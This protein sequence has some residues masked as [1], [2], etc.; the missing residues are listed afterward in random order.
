MAWLL[1]NFV[2]SVVSIHATWN[3]LICCKTGLIV[4]VKT[5]HIAFNP[6]CSNVPKQVAHLCCP[7][8]PLKHTAVSDTEYSGLFSQQADA[9]SWSKSKKTLYKR[10]TAQQQAFLPGQNFQVSI[11]QLGHLNPFISVRFLL[12]HPFFPS[13]GQEKLSWCKSED[14]LRCLLMVFCI[15]ESFTYKSVLPQCFW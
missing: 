3:N 15:F 4:G 5:R 10:L 11:Y 1:L 2:Q 13:L 7:R 14:L 9:A 8:Y 12:K 6:F